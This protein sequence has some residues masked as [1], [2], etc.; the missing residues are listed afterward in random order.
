ML[1]SG[2]RVLV[3]HGD[4]ATRFHVLKNLKAERYVAADA[5]RGRTVLRTM[6]EA[7][8]DLI[9]PRFDRPDMDGL[10]STRSVRQ[11][12]P[13]H[14]SR[15][16]SDVP[17]LLVERGGKVLTRRGRLAAI[18]DAGRAEHVRHLRVAIRARRHKIE[19]APERPRHLPTEPCVGDR[20]KT[21]ATR[22]GDG[23]GTRKS[24]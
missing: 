18:G 23:H 19:H 22:T 1:T 9:V 6:A 16:E 15:I 2:P 7:A 10:A 20:M 4:P 5:A 17:H 14:L 12:A 21:P 13:V 3:A 8:P 11:I 24:A